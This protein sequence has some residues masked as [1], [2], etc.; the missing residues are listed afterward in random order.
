MNM[1]TIC[2]QAYNKS[3]LHKPL[4]GWDGFSARA[5]LQNRRK[6]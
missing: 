4:R 3:M 6:C 2:Q 1:Q 5:S